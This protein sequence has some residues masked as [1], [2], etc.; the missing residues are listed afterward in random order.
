MFT[1]KCQCGY[2]FEFKSEPNEKF[3]NDD[4]FYIS[5]NGSKI[6]FWQVHDKVGV[7]CDKCNKGLWTFT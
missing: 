2:E 1:I 6:R 7:W 3:D 5:T 4:G